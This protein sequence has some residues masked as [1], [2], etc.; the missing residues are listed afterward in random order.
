[1]NAPYGTG[2]DA[3]RATGE[4]G[5]LPDEPVGRT[6]GVRKALALSGDGLPRYGAPGAG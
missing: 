6:A 1:M 5:R 2:E 3:T 4:P